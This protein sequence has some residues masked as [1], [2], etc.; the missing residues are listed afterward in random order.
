MDKALAHYIKDKFLAKGA[1]DVVVS[2]ATDKRSQVKFHNS[3]ISTTMNW[4]LMS[5]SLFISKDKKLAYTTV[6]DLNKESINSAVD[7][8]IKF[9]ESTA[10]NKEFMGIAEGPFS[11]RGIREN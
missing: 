8:L 3:G 11:Y 2:L 6:K 4:D 1:D 5:A 9:A 10:P 7:K